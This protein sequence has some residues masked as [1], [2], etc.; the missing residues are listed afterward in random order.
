MGQD[1]RPNK[2]IPIELLLLL[3]ELTK[4]KIQEAILLR[5]K[6]R[7]L[8]FHAYVMVCYTVSLRGCEGFLLDFEGLNQKFATGGTKHA[9]IA[10]RGQIKGESDD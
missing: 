8:V 10:L 2:A 6:H 9:G 7:G 5:D 4:L 3:L 1:W